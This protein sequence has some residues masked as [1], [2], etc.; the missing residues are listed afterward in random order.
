[1]IIILLTP[2]VT[3]NLAEHAKK[4]LDNQSLFFI[5]KMALFDENIDV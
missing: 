3:K 1:M 2:R 4:F 5:V